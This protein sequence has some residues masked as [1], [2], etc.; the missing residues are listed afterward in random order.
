VLGS[1]LLPYATVRATAVGFVADNESRSM[2]MN[3]VESRACVLPTTMPDPCPMRRVLNSEIKGNPNFGKC[4]T[5]ADTVVRCQLSTNATMQARAGGLGPKKGC[6]HVQGACPGYLDRIKVCLCLLAAGERERKR[7][8][9]CVCVCE[10]G[11]GSTHPRL[12]LSPHLK[13]DRM[14]HGASSK[15]HNGCVCNEVCA[16][17][18]ASNTTIIFCC[19]AMIGGR[20]GQGVVV[21][22]N[23]L[24]G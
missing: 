19:R 1:V 22:P 7:E 2:L 11:G 12:R 20:F 21:M 4:L 10:G 3:V 23:P 6:V 16:V 8:S 14:P 13:G 18:R 15:P 9:V 5:A 24:V 17:I